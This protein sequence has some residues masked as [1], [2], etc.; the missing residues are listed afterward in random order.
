MKMKNLLLVLISVLAVMV[1]CN[2]TAQPESPDSPKISGE[3]CNVT[4]SGIHFTKSVN[5]ANSLI[6]VNDSNIITFRS[7][8]GKDFFSDPD[9]KLSNNTA[10]ILLSRIDNTQPFTLTAKV[11]PD[12]KEMY[13]AGTLYLYVNDSFWQKFAFEMDERKN[14]RIVTVRTIDYSDDNNHDVVTQESAYM[15]ISSDTQ[16]VGLYYS[17]DN[18]NWQLARL[19]KNNYPNELWVGIGAQSPMGDGTEVIF[20][21]C[22]LKTEAVKDFRMGK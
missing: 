21:D 2:K 10:P 18:E 11:T 7:E 8:G 20:S 13:D 9:G 5:D 6:S 16:T 4:I 15:K 3:E 17:L 22:S 19:Y 1:S 14:H 12:F